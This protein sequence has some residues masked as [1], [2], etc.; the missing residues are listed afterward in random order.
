MTRA[1][2]ERCAT[3]GCQCREAGRNCTDPC[4]CNNAEDDG[5]CDNDVDD[6]DHELSSVD[7]VDDDHDDD[8]DEE[9]EEEEVDQG[10]FIFVREL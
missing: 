2:K 9:K 7:N 6:Y 3:N 8:D 1:I 10:P 5:G 4:S